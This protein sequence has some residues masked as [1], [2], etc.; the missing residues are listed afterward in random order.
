M[1]ELTE[2]IVVY[3]PMEQLFDS[4]GKDIG[5]WL[6]CTTIFGAYAPFS[7][8]ILDS[9]IPVHSYSKELVV[10]IGFHERMA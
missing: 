1:L 5:S 6:K 2:L 9:F 3:H 10:I 8:L 7:V 4:V